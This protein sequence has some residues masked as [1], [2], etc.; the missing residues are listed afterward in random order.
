MFTDVPEPTSTTNVITCGGAAIAL[1]NRAHP[2]ANM[3]AATNALALIFM[4]SLL[5]PMSLAI[6]PRGM[7]WLRIFPL[8]SVVAGEQE[9]YQF[10]DSRG[11]VRATP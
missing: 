5:F 9:L 8:L 3:T 7:R 6:R 2:N 10:A 11:A 1:P 4:R